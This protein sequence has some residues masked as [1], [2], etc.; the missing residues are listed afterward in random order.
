MCLLIYCYCI[1]A[2]QMWCLGKHLPLMVGNLVP[3]DDERWILFC[4]LLEIVDIVFS[5]VTCIDTIGVLEGLIE[6]HHSKFRALYPGRSII[7]KMH[8]MVHYPSHMNRYISSKKS[9]CTCNMFD[10]C[11]YILEQRKKLI[12]MMKVLPQVTNH[13]LVVHAR[14]L[15]LFQL[16]FVPET[17]G[18]LV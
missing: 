5:P 7:P 16:C 12:F 15:Y 10:M 4:T 2:A 11:T 8:Y 13:V 18:L 3:E 14:K 17:L 9:I 1:S 6:E